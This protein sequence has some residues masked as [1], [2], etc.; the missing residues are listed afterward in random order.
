MLPGARRW[1]WTACRIPGLAAL[2]ETAR[3]CPPQEQDEQ[4]DQDNDDD[5]TDAYVH[6]SSCA[7]WT[8]CGE[9]AAHCP[10]PADPNLRGYGKEDERGYGKEDEAAR[11]MRPAGGYVWDRASREAHIASADR[12]RRTTSMRFPARQARSPETTGSRVGI[13]ERIPLVI[14]GPQDAV[15]AT[16]VMSPPPATRARAG[17]KSRG[18][19]MAQRHL[20]AAGKT[21]PGP[22]QPVP[23]RRR[24]PRRQRVSPWTAPST[25]LIKPHRRR[26]SCE[27][28]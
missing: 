11:L 22:A 5:G 16:D 23:K 15:S 27:P 21:A 12:R 20:C 13:A 7:S 6:G 14:S 25:L 28:A 19:R 26:S 18:P 1:S 4:N 17:A 8:S 9:A 2:E 3:S 10:Q 24:R